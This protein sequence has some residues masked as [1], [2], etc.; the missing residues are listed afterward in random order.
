[1]ADSTIVHFTFGLNDPVLEKA[2]LSR[3]TDQLLPE[4]RQRDEVEQADL[5]QVPILKDG[6]KGYEQLWGWL[7]ADASIKNLTGFL[8]WLGGRLSDR[9]SKVKVKLGDKEIE[10]EGESLT[11]PEA[12]AMRIIA[13]LQ[14]Q[15][16]A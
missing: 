14:G 1:M 4:L 11:D 10:L 13:A 2:D 6:A 9:P 3:F 15:P 5:I 8:T 12:T 7:S 16:G